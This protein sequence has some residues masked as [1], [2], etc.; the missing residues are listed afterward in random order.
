VKATEAKKPPEKLVEMPC[1]V[2]GR[3]VT[4]FYGTWGNSG[5]CSRKCEQEQDKKSRFFFDGR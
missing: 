5:T 4:A 2:C 3:P 1:M